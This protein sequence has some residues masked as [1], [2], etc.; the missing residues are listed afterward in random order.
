MTHKQIIKAIKK[1]GFRHKYIADKLGVSQNSFSKWI[2]N[3]F[4][5]GSKKSDAINRKEQIMEFLGLAMK[6][7]SNWPIYIIMFQRISF[8]LDVYGSM[9]SNHEKFLTELN[10]IRRHG[11][12]S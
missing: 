1:S 6:W 10:K 7:L 11:K 9:L 3:G 12:R 5:D 2:K 8:E 4:P